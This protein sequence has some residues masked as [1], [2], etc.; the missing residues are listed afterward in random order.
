MRVEPGDNVFSAGIYMPEKPVLEALRRRIAADARPF[1]AHPALRR[2]CSRICRCAPIR[3]VRVPRGFP[4]DHP[5]GELIR[6]RNYLVR[7]TYSDAEIARERRVRDVPRSDARLSR[8]SC[9]IIQ[10]R[11]RRLGPTFSSAAMREPSDGWDE[12]SSSD[13]FGPS[14][15]GEVLIAQARNARTPLGGIVRG[16]EGEAIGAP[17][18]HARERVGDRHAGQLSDRHVEREAHRRARRSPDVAPGRAAH[19]RVAD[20]Q[21]QR[22]E[23]RAERDRDPRIAFDVVSEF[24][25]H[26]EQRFVVGEF[27]EQRIGDRDA[28]GAE[29][30]GHE[31]VGFLRLTAHVEAQDRRA[32]DAVARGE[33]ADALLRA[34][35]RAECIC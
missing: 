31:R 26:D 5:R 17:F 13:H 8:R 28:F 10:T 15:F 27:I 25:R 30:A 35:L 21:R 12:N 9:A 4:K 34:R 6:A 20:E 29:H 2:R 3:C 7:R 11:R 1:D 22:G 18:D 19:R 32:A 23:R 33:R 24:V 16:G 14:I